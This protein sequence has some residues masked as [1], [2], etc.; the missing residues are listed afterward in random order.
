MWAKSFM[1]HGLL[2]IW[3]SNYLREHQMKLI[4]YT[5]V[6]VALLVAIPA[7]A[8][9]TGDALTACLADNTTGKD[10]KDLSRWIFAAM[11][12]HP[13]M[14]DIASATPAARERTSE[15]V[16]LLITRLMT[17][18]CTSQLRAA[19][20]AEGSQALTAAFDALG[21][22]AMQELTANA[23]VRKA[24]GGFEQYVDRKKVEAAVAN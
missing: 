2:A 12:A 9:P 6:A 19:S 17:E 5:L 24:I 7:E 4:T 20:K 16:G 21:R 14:Q 10:R 3:K 23:D 22:L 11:S 15:A 8:G 18:S 13:A 1:G